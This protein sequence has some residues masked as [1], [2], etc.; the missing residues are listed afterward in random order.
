MEYYSA[1]KRNK[2]LMQATK[3][4][5]LENTMLKERNQSFKKHIMFLPVQYDV[6]CG[7]VMNSFYYF[8]IHSIDT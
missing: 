4:I 3:L 6:G 8:E 5:T 1:V 7:F 2:V